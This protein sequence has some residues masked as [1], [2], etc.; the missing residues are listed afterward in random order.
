MYHKIL[1]L[2]SISTNY[3]K[4]MSEKDGFKASVAVY[5]KYLAKE[6]LRKL[7]PVKHILHIYLG[8]EIEPC[9]NNNF[10]KTISDAEQNNLSKMIK[11]GFSVP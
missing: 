3:L 1:P 10:D 9:D 8:E 11:E 5:S 2:C 6:S 7:L 4:D